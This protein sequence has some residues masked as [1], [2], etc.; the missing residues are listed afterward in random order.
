MRFQRLLLSLLIV[1]SSALSKSASGQAVEAWTLRGH[2][3]PVTAVAFSPDG[4]T[5]ASASADSTIKIWNK[6]TGQLLRTLTGH[7]HGVCCIAYSP[8]GGLLASGGDDAYVRLWDATSGTLRVRLSEN[9]SKVRC[10]TFSPN[11]ERLAAGRQDSSIELWNVKSRTLA[12]TFKGH[13]KAV[14]TV[15]FTPTGN[16]LVSGSADQAVKLWSLARVCEITPEPLQHRGQHGAIRSLAFSPTGVE[17]AMTTN[18]FVAIWEFSQLERRFALKRR[19]KGVIWSA[20]YSPQGRLLATACGIDPE[21][22]KSGK[23]EKGIG[24]ERAET[25]RE[26][27]IRLWDSATGRECGSLNGHSG[28][29]RTLDFS[30]DGLQLAS[31][32]DDKAVMVWDVAHYDKFETQPAETADLTYPTGNNDLAASGGIEPADPHHVIC[33]ENE[34]VPTV[35]IEVDGATKAVLSRPKGKEP[36]STTSR[37]TSLQPHSSSGKSSAVRLPRREKRVE[38]CRGRST[39]WRRWRRWR[40]FWGWRRRRTREETRLVGWSRAHA[41]FE[42]LVPVLDTNSNPRHKP[43][44]RQPTGPAFVA[45]CSATPRRLRSRKHTPS[46]SRSRRR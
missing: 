8:D 31:G 23:C 10:L 35:I 36:K 3:A 26:N 28:P 13:K 32:S 45:V 5:L 25:R 41:I 2:T 1:S 14:L 34:D 38:Q 9:T 17:L 46:H 11:G 6:K 19:R 44:V 43:S 12:A 27:E 40:W 16:L 20:R 33:N 29:V 42:R 4:T 37:W 15:A 22:S 21:S 7:V 30:T 18:D 24:G 39:F